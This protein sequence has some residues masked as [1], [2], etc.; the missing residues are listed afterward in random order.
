MKPLSWI[1]IL[2]FAFG[3]GAD[4]S[5]S[6]RYF[7][8]DMEEY[9]T[10][11]SVLSEDRLLG[12]DTGSPG[13]DAASKYIEDYIDG[14]GLSPGGT[15]NSFRQPIKFRTSQLL[16]PSARL[17]I[18]NREL[19]FEE[20]FLI[21]AYSDSNAV[22]INAPLVFAGFGIHTPD[23]GYSDF[24]DIDVSG[25]V[26][27]IIRGSPDKFDMVQQA[28]TSSAEVS[29]QLLQE[30]G[31]LAVIRVIPP[32][33]L[34]VRSWGS[35]IGRANRMGLN[36]V[37]NDQNGSTLPT[38]VLHHQSAAGIF[39]NVGKDF[40]AT[41]SDLLKG[42]PNSF[43]LES[44]VLI[45]ANFNHHEIQSHN[46]AGVIEG[47]DSEAN[48]EYLVISSHLD[49]IGIGAPLNGDSIYNGTLDNASGAAALMVMAKAFK[50]LPQPK[51]SIMFLWVTA[52]EK[53]LLGSEYFAKYPTVASN[54]I[55][56]NLNID[57]IIG[58][59][60]ESKDVIAYGYQHS[61]L[62]ES[63]DFAVNSM[64]MEVSPDP[65]PEQNI[66][67]RSDQYSFV[68]QG[69]PALYV[70]SGRSAVDPQK[71]ALKLFNHWLRTRYHQ[72][73]DDMQQPMSLSGIE[74]ELEFNFLI[75]DHIANR[76]D[77]IQWHQDS[78]LYQMFVK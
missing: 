24:S 43:D 50:E 51:R 68:K 15:D 42:D 32:S 23:L 52:E 41:L 36:Y 66:F 40:N 18:N 1:G 10:H 7:P 8:V 58:M 63:V 28:V 14:L 48:G 39:E 64:G 11:L 20:E 37:A 29:N 13:F 17:A 26:V 77:K 9:M 49:H 75:A 12:R 45:S 33:Y 62:S 47:S 71:D 38:V 31:A 4:T 59:I 46:L 57:G 74:R 22:E 69:Y 53:G 67:V 6:T 21:P 44:N 30:M 65:L 54:D 3:C 2:V 27:M 35:L 56:A 70:V 55:A 76:P 34:N 5:E 61:N 73:S 78:F 19:V 16:K 25:K 60:A 72:P